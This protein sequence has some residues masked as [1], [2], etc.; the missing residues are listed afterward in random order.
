MSR[1][2]LKDAIDDLAPPPPPCFL[3]NVHWIEY[4]Y[5]AAATQNNRGEQKIILIVDGEPRINHA[6]NFCEDC[7]S[8]E[9]KE[10]QKMMGLC[11]PD[12]LK[13]LE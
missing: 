4:L 8:K 12:H 10:H 9:H 2:N 3:N 6:F 1:L 11:R 5:S 13:G 7:E